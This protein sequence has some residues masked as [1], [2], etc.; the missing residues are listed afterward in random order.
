MLNTTKLAFVGALA[1]F[2]HAAFAAGDPA[3][4]A[5]AE[6]QY[7]E[8]L[9][10]RAVGGSARSRGRLPI[11][12]AFATSV[13]LSSSC[14]NHGRRF[15]PRRAKSARSP[16]TGFRSATSSCRPVLKCSRAAVL[17]VEGHAP[18]GL[19]SVEHRGQSLGA[20]D[21][22]PA[23]IYRAVT[24]KRRPRAVCLGAAAPPLPPAR[25]PHR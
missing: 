3:R 12:A 7:R 22:E 5:P 14:G 21:P 15:R 24:R 11:R 18:D 25:G 17:T 4:G 9:S 13:W 16:A 6:D 10:R 20:A 19:D 2:A 1:I 23:A 8:R